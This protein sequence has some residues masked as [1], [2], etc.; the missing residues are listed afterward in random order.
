LNLGFTQTMNTSSPHTQ[1]ADDGNLMRHLTQRQPSALVVLHQRYRS[2]LLHAALQIV[3]DEADAEEIVQD[4]FLQ[5]WTRPEVYCA[6]KGKPVSWLLTL[7]RRRAIDCVRRRAALRRATER[8]GVRE[9]AVENELAGT[10]RR[11]LFN[12]DLRAYLAAVMEQLPPAQQEV[13]E[14]GFFRQKSQRQIAAELRLPLGTIKTR[15][16]LG[17]RKLAR[18]LEPCRAQ[19]E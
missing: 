6:D 9:R 18:L 5:I 19:V 12:G 3:H 10:V 15:M 2:L 14:Q 13:V 17:L 16:E 7:S 8:F 11:E 4:V 1:D